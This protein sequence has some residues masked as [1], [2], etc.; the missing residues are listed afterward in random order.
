ME[1]HSHPHNPSH[2]KK[3]TEYFFE[4][5]MIFLAVTLGFIAENIREER[6]NHTKEKE[7]MKSMLQDVVSDTS[8]LNNEMYFS[9]NIGKGL[10]SLSIALY[11]VDGSN[12]STLNIYRLHATYS[13]VIGA[14]FNDL[15]S[16]QLRNSGGM[17]FIKKSTVR[18]AIADYWKRVTSIEEILDRLNNS[19]DADFAYSIFN[20]SYEHFSVDSGSGMSVVTI[21]P[22][23]RIMTNDKNQLIN[24]ANRMARKVTIIN[25][26][27][28]RKLKIQ[29]KAAIEL[30]G[31]LKKEY[32]LD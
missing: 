31:L 8:M 18:S 21:D 13:R 20:R 26:F 27:L 2:K 15:T 16:I 5:L 4:F 22:S 7:Y 1:V 10:D 24:Y 3:W 9:T 30:I 14:A 29:K 6:I 12:G 17:Q 11:S 28:V 25:N 32:H 23:A 19:N